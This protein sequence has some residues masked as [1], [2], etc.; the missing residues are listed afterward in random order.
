M[1][2]ASIDEQLEVIR[3]GTVQIFPEEEL[4]E[5]LKASI[6]KDRPLRVKLGVD[7]TAPD[8]HLGHTVQLRKL[9]AFQELGHLV[10]LI[11][12]DGTALIGDP[13]GQK[14]TRP[15]LSRA[16]VAE[17]A[18]TYLAQVSKVLDMG[19]AEVV[20][21]G[22]WFGQMTFFDVVKLA[23][24]A[25]V[26]RTLERD[27]FAERMK[28]G[29]PIYVH[30]MLYP[31]MQGYDSVMVKSDIEIGGTDQ[32]FNLLVGRDLQRDAGQSPQVILTMP[33]IEGIDG[34]L[35]MSKSLGNYVGVTEAPAEMFGKVMSI[36][37]VLMRKYYELLTSVPM[38]EV[39]TLL[40]DVTHPRDAKVRLAREIVTLYYNRQSAEAAA[41]EFDRV[42]AQGAL[43]D[44]VPVVELP[45]DKLTD[46]RL[47]VVA[48]V[49]ALGLAKSNA[50]ARRL[51]GQGGVYL[52]GRRMNNVDAEV[53]VKTGMIVQ[54]GRRKFARVKRV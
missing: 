54:V 48:L 43:P 27:D 49:T 40:S 23:S 29:V 34:T 44:D 45:E 32:T 24:K 53:P 33:I 13:S 28:A 4:V 42:F 37:D 11:I 35:K 9:R 16:E 51:V 8:I 46:G 17:N 50:E 21:N 12:G 7:P 47:W 26:A 15:Q 3:R 19:R 30:E 14:S 20:R 52:D 6:A 5:K 38:D 10:V 22:D 36:P 1:T 2:F 31:L 18:V 39:E 25:T 41:A